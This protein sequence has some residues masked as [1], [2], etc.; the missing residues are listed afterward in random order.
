[1]SNPKYLHGPTLSDLKKS[2]RKDL[3]DLQY[4]YLLNIKLDESLWDD[5]LSDEF[6]K[7]H[8]PFLLPDIIDSITIIKKFLLEK[9]ILILFI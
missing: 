5:F 4:N 3:T 1:M 6:L 9:K 8:S 2:K 7:T